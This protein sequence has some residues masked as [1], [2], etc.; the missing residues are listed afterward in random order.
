MRAPHPT[1]RRGRGGSFPTLPVEGQD[2]AWGEQGHTDI[3]T[4][5]VLGLGAVAICQTGVEG[6]RNPGNRAEVEKH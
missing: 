6:E 1:P 2:R 4:T 3:E 5:C